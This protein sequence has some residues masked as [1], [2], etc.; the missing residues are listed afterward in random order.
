M[1]LKRCIKNLDSTMNNDEFILAINNKIESLLEAK[2]P[3]DSNALLIQKRFRALTNPEKSSNFSNSAGSSYILFIENELREIRQALNIKAKPSVDY[4]F[5]NINPKYS[6][7]KANLILDN[8]RMENTAIRIQDDTGMH[9]ISPIQIIKTFSMYA[10]LQMETLINLYYTVL[11][12]DNFSKFKTAF[13]NSNKPPYYNLDKVTTIPL[14]P[15]AAKLQFF[16]KWSNNLPLNDLSDKAIIITDIRNGNVHR[17]VELDLDNN[18][19]IPYN[20]KSKLIDVF[21]ELKYFNQVRET[22]INFVNCVKSKNV[23]I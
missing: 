4:S 20:T 5:L 9:V 7:V 13:N 19:L 1:R 23:L 12:N 15:L 8:L 2:G 16:L 18:Y 10:S 11:Y 3:D 22:L 14:A 17:A 21:N 6:Q